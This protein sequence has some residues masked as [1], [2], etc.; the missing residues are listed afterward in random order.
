V[1]ASFAHYTDIRLI[2]AQSPDRVEWLDRFNDGPCSSLVFASSW[3]AQETLTLQVLERMNRRTR[4]IGR[5]PA[6]RKEAGLR[7]LHRGYIDNEQHNELRWFIDLM[8]GGRVVTP[9][10]G[11]PVY[12]GVQSPT[13]LPLGGVDPEYWHPDAVADK[14]KQQ[15]G[16]PDYPGLLAEALRP[17]PATGVGLPWYS[18]FGNHDGLLQG[19]VPRNAALAAT[20]TGPLKLIGPPPGLDPCDFVAGVQSISGATPARL[21]TADAARRIVTRA[22]YIAEHFTTSGTPVG[23]G[24]TARNRR[25]GTA[26]YV[27]DDHPRLR[28][29]SLDTVNPGGH[30]DGSVG[31]A[32]LRWLE[33]RLIEVHGFYYDGNGNGVATGNGDRLVVLFSHHGLRSLNNPVVAPDPSTPG[34]N[35]LPRHMAPE[36][37]ALLHRFPNVVAWVDGHTHDN[38]ID[39]RADPSGRTAASGTSAR[40]RTST[41]SARRA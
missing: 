6:T 29:I 38:V 15:F 1:L 2:D 24:F 19:N 23:Q 28:L 5:G 9:N 40:R 27:I 30:A 8:D 37:E 21:V 25:D 16:Y 17:F 36:V 22:D 33:E 14:Y 39:P 10:S 32:Q 41:G 11:G 3:R 31:D 7:H 20:A 12:E 18:A 34:A 35:D 13:W 4:A 26:Y